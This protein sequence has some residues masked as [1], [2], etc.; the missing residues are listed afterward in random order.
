MARLNSR[1][2]AAVAIFASLYAALRLIP[3]S[4]LIGVRS[5]LTMGEIFSPLAGMVLGPLAGGLSILV[6]TF[7]TAVMG[8]P[9]VFDGLDFI[10]GVIAAVTAGL[11]I[12][13]RIFWSVGLSVLLITVFS[14]D[15]LSTT[16]VSVGQLTVPFLWM[17]M[18]AVVAAL[19]V[20]WRVGTGST[21]ISN[22]VFMA[23]VVFISTMNAHVSGSIMFENVLVRINGS[24]EPNALAATW[25]FIFYVYPLE[26]LFFLIVGSF[27]AIPV[28]R[29]VPT[30]TLEILR[31][32]RKTVA[33]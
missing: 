20:A 21:A 10:P 16:T 30:Q 19:V 1:R 29:T 9:L 31:G 6:G 33:A 28:L 5:S 4:P 8:R 11:A 22:P 13:G 25:K 7:L 18:L 15:P 24:L 14:V 12:Q 23:T 17:H 2:I 3:V 27:L 32:R 26:R